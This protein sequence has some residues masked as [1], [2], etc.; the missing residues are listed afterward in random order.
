MMKTLVIFAH[1]NSDSFNGA[2]RYVVENQ[3]KENGVEYIVKDLYAMNFNGILTVN[4]LMQMRK[5]TVAD[6]IALEQNDVRWAENLIFIFPIW[7]IAPPAIVKGW[8]DRVLSHG[9]A[10]EHQ[11]DGTIKGLLGDK[12]ALIITTSGA[13]QE[14]MQNEGTLEAIE[15]MLIKGIFNFS[16]I[17][18]VTYENLFQVTSTTD[19]K[20]QE[21]LQQVASLV[22]R[23]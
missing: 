18:D 15:T 7:W 13:N 17:S 21:M 12:R 11:E 19:E 5:G 4:D 9:F 2:I 20:R 14:K 8:I 16:G 3:L 23:L 10:Y 1:P 22:S 6:D